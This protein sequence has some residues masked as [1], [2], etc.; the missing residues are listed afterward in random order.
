MYAA[1]AFPE[2]AELFADP[3]GGYQLLG[4]AHILAGEPPVTGF[5]TSYGPLVFY[6]SALAQAVSD[7]RVMGEMILVCLGFAMGYW[8]YLR[9]VYRLTMHWVW[10]LLPALLAV[11]LMPRVYKY[12]LV[13]LPFLC[14]SAM[15]HYL[16]SPRRRSLACLGFAVAITGLFRPDFGIYALIAAGVAAWLKSRSWQ[17]V[18]WLMFWTLVAAAP[19]LIYV[20]IKGGLLQYLLDSSVGAFSGAQGLALPLPVTHLT[21]SW[22]NVGNVR[23]FLFLFYLIVPAVSGIVLLADRSGISGELRHKLVVAT[24]FAQL[25]LLQAMHRSD[26]GHLLQ[27]IPMSLVLVAWLCGHGFASTSRSLVARASA[28][29]AASILLL[30]ALQIGLAGT[31]PP[32]SPRRLVSKI[33]TYTEP[34][35]HLERILARRDPR[36]ENARM[37]AWIRV[38]T[39]QQ[40]RV[41][42]LPASPQFIFLSQRLVIG[43]Q[44]ALMP[45]HF[46]SEADQLA[47]VAA[48]EQ[49]DATL[50]VMRRGFSLDDKPS[51]RL[52]AYAP[53]V[54]D[55]LEK[56]YSRVA[57]FGLFD[58]LARPGR[59]SSTTE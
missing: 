47:L 9:L 56:N 49:P 20:G 12:Y 11:G 30:S 45:G 55:C 24:V 37:V 16:D 14:L 43:G 50:V 31:I 1:T 13:L 19:W 8:L 10:S 26:W 34:I 29:L 36:N 44:L 27:A 25:C 3:D 59:I 6:M 35:P 18:S 15:F 33:H 17:V 28:I 41:L 38:H 42:A 22:I 48:L 53:L 51:R 7:K 40:D 54:T 58:V 2:L 5:R 4:A 57:Q 52:D 21:E 32:L 39:R 23:S 46:S